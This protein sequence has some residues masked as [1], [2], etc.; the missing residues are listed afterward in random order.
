MNKKKLT[1]LQSLKPYTMEEIDEML[2]A[3][4]NDFV[5]GDYVTNEEV[6]ERHAKML[7]KL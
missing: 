6:K 5:N 4:E 3:A 2:T 7:S 1:D